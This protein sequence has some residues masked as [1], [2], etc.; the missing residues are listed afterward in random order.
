MNKLLHL[1][2]VLEVTEAQKSLKEI[3]II[4]KSE[5]YANAGLGILHRDIFNVLK[6]KPNAEGTY[7]L[8]RYDRYND[9]TYKAMSY[10]ETSN[11]G[12]F[13]SDRFVMHQVAER[14]T[15]A[16][17]ISLLT[18]IELWTPMTLTKVQRVSFAVKD[19]YTFL[20]DHVYGIIVDTNP[21]D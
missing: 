16:N 3:I 11:V 19:M 9:K 15:I 13:G 5:K 14:Q 8:Y 20:D 21:E 2:G 10:L 18:G 4:T 7:V 12:M 1:E 6:I 17:Q